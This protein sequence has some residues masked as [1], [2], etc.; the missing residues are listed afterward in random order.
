MLIQNKIKFVLFYFINIVIIIIICLIFYG[1]GLVICKIKSE[2]Y[3][4]KR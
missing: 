3:F 1:K 2:N 4:T